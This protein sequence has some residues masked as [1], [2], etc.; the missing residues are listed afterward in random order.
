MTSWWALALVC[1]L[2]GQTVR[3]PLGPGYLTPLDLAV[4][5]GWVWIL[6]RGDVLSQMKN[7]TWGKGFLLVVGT[8]V[9]SLIPALFLFELPTVLAGSLYLVRFV[10]YGAAAVIPFSRRDLRVVRTGMVYALGGTA[11]LGIAQFILF[12]NLAPLTVHGWDPHW[13][14]LVSTWLDPNY[15]GLLLAAGILYVLT[16]GLTARKWDNRTVLIGTVLFFAL[17]LTFSRSAYLAFVVMSGLSLLRFRTRENALLVVLSVTLLSA[18][19]L[20]RLLIEQYRDINRSESARAR[21]LSYRK[22]LKIAAA[23]PFGVGFNLYRDAQVALRLLPEGTVS[24]GSTGADSSFLFLL[25]TTGFFGLSAWIF[26]LSRT[27][28]T[29]AK[30][31][32]GSAWML[33]CAMFGWMVHAQFVNSLVFPPLLFFFWSWLNEVT[34]A[35]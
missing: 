32:T 27:L 9:I 18:S 19:L 15:V 17:L 6:A 25:A 2:L 34:R 3:I 7:T 10:L 29:L 16:P 28:G 21:V 5:V 20:P 14:R 11:G 4:V 30:I 12:P 31:S 13:Y 26:W 22:A 8:L 24:H 35:V 1:F 23:H 33:F